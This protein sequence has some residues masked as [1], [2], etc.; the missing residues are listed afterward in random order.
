MKKILL[1]G[2]AMGWLTI[3]LAGVVHAGMIG[4]SEIKV[5][6]ALTPPAES[7]LQIC[8]LIATETG[9]GIDVALASNG[10]TAT[11]TSNW[12]QQTNPGKAI[13]G[14]YPG[15]YPNLWHSATN[16]ATE[17]L[18]VMLSVPKELDSITIYGRNS[19]SDRDVFNVYA[20]DSKGNQLF[21]GLNASAN[22]ANHYVTLT[23]PN[24]PVPEPSSML[25]LATGL[26]GLAGIRFRR[27]KQ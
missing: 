8:E 25:L 12:D 4:V 13:D 6:S 18:D 26:A 9:T 22:N 27:K 20:Y 5:F 1:V 21:A 19:Y 10:A 14:I 24:T 15:D 7:Y 16:S 3:S 17:Y 11:S 2:L 23:F